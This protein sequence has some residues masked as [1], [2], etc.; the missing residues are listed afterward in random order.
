MGDTDAVHPLVSTEEK[1][2]DVAIGATPPMKK[3]VDYTPYAP[4][5]GRWSMD[6]L[7]KCATSNVQNV[8]RKIRYSAKE[9]ND[10]NANWPLAY[11]AHQD[12]KCSSAFATHF[13]DMVLC[14]NG[15]LCVGNFCK[16]YAINARLWIRHQP[17]QNSDQDTSVFILDV[18]PIVFRD[19]PVPSWIQRE[20]MNAVSIIANDVSYNSDIPNVIEGNA[21]NLPTN[22]AQLNA[23]AYNEN[24]RRVLATTEFLANLPLLL[25][26]WGAKQTQEQSSGSA[27]TKPKRALFRLQGMPHSTIIGDYSTRKLQR[28][29]DAANYC[30]PL[31]LQWYRAYTWLIPTVLARFDEE[32]VSRREMN[33]MVQKREPV[34]ED[35]SRAAASALSHNSNDEDSQTPMFADSESESERGLISHQSKGDAKKSDSSQCCVM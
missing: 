16:P 11:E 2:P 9:T 12:D 4:T 25:S 33:E 26:R 3:S 32:I 6:Y 22:P 29:S 18:A 21:D 24:I 1:E 27:D 23:L 30:G 13:L 31:L 5:D 34:C 8:I 7:M 28:L 17:Q 10:T 20:V 15:S 19:V 14:S 35:E